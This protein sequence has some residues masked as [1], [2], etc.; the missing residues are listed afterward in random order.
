MKVAI[1]VDSFKGSLSSREVADAF[2]QGLRI[3]LPDC[4]VV[5]VT[6]ADGGEGTMEALVETL[7]GEF[8]EVEVCDPL[9]RPIKARYGTIDNGNTAIIDIATASGLPLLKEEERN[10]LYT[11]TYGTGELVANAL[12]H[13]CRKFFIGLG[14]S[15][16]N[17]AGV[18]MFRALGFRFL[19][20][21]G[22][23]LIGGGEILEHIADIDDSAVVPELFDSTFIAACD[24]QNRLFGKFGAAYTFAPQK[25]ADK[26]AVEQLDSGLRNFA[27]VVAGYNGSMIA[28][29]EGGGA[30]GGVGGGVVALLNA[31][32]VR[33][34][35]MVLNAMHFDKIIEGCDL[36]VTGEGRIDNQT[37]M[38]KAPSG[39]LRIA[40]SKNIPTIAIG[41]GVVWCNELR[42]SGFAS[43]EV[44]T[45]E[46]MEVEEA[47]TPATAKENIRQAAERIAK[48]FL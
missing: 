38:G 2:E 15:A 22:K 40:Q 4:E 5:K 30:A 21:S 24:V 39:V 23:E 36:V 6:I 9:H 42:N 44:V 28:L 27:R 19:D 14:G 16:T 33:G 47:M 8:V 11:S 34:I 7:K 43:I 26:E 25:G 13:G 3:Q 1:A 48:R 10:P 29:I 17:D 12:Q 32:L 41:G 45:P 18:G 20:H 31:R 46:G 35:D 37:I